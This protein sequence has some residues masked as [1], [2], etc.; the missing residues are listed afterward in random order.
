MIPVGI[1]TAAS[2]STGN[3]L[4]DLYPDSA[5][6]YSLRKLRTSYTGNAIRVRRSS[7]NTEINIGFVLN[8]LDTATLLTFCGAG[9]GFI[10][11]WYDQSGNARD[12]IQATTAKQPQIVSSGVVIIINTKPSVFFNATYFLLHT[13]NPLT[14]SDFSAF[15]VDKYNSVPGNV[16]VGYSKIDIAFNANLFQ[17]ADRDIAPIKTYSPVLTGLVLHNSIS[18]V[19]G[20]TTTARAFLNNVDKGTGSRNL[21]STKTSISIGASE[22]GTFGA[23]QNISEF[24]LYSSDQ[25][26]N[27]NGINTNIN[28][29]YTIY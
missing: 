21:T 16:F 15:L 20:A 5:A 28:T 2:T 11:I 6:A 3:L 14:Y 18:T 4:L 22:T 29:F 1:L 13:S 26:A 25:S 12:A 8:V 7:D 19:S 10:T 23:N 27:R 9:N 17:I 24:I